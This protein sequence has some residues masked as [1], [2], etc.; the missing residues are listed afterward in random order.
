M[1]SRI[2][3]Q[4][5]LLLTELPTMVTVED[6]DYSFEFSESYTANLHFSTGSESIPF[7]MPLDSALEQLRQET[8]NS[9]LLTIEHNTV[10]IFTD[11][12]GILKIFD[13]HARDSFGMPHSHGTC[14]LLEFDSIRN[15]T[16]YLKFIYRFG[17]IFELRG[18]KIVNIGCSKQLE[19]SN[20]TVTDSSTT[21]NDTNFNYISSSAADDTPRE[22]YFLY[23]REC[24]LYIYSICFSTIMNC[25]YWTYQTQSDIIEH[26]IEMYNNETINDK[27]QGSKH[28]PGSIEICGSQ[29]DIVNTS[30]HEGTLCLA[31]LSSRV[32]LET[33]I[34]CNAKQNTGF[35]IW[36]SNH[37]LGCV[38]VNQR[39]QTKYFI[40][41]SSETRELNLLKPFSDPHPLVSRFCDILELTDPN[42]EE[43]EYLIQFLSCKTTL[44]KSEKQKVQRK[45]KYTKQ[46]EVLCENK[47]K[48]YKCMDP[49]KRE[50]LCNKNALKYKSL[51]PSEKEA[52]LEKQ[53]MSYKEMGT[54]EKEAC[55]ERNKS[56]MK[57]KYHVINSPQKEKKQEAYK[58]SKSTEHNLDYFICNFQNKIREG[59]CYICCVCNRL[60]Y[61]KSVKLLNRNSCNSSVPKSVF[62]NITSFDNKEYICSTCH[63]KVA[64]GKI[65]CQ[66]VCNNMSVDEIPV[67][68][69]LLEKLEQILIA[70]RIV[71]EKII[72]MP[73][74]QQ[75]KVSGAICNVPVDC[76]Q[77]CKVLPR[78]P[79]RS[80][81]IMLKLK[82]KL[83]FRGHVYFQAVR[84][85]F[86]ENALNWLKLNNPLYFNV[87]TEMNNIN[88][89]L[90]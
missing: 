59:P 47:T 49:I 45:H 1:L 2:S 10:S 55:L 76:D 23:T 61:K 73:K 63:S 79:E 57:R 32:P 66:A 14:V 24:S 51:N 84:P 65:P 35:F 46:K 86:I 11:S 50:A 48:I 88:V 67:E 17:A 39:Q 41:S 81:I 8:F 25:S 33:V 13:S 77:T 3:R 72:I 44:T 71:F 85:Q 74:G 28:F 34:L 20:E 64:K 27:N 31:S 52:L 30:I 69:A 70:Q 37:C 18:V 54:S 78:P 42:I 9:F 56:N 4:S 26:A 29:I 90:K 36:L 15:F 16:E 80:G 75:K 68:L 6:T 7:V 38:I 62:T 53:A 87:T 40:L 21:N 43:V 83:E 82:R 58:K 5:Y 12:S 19:N 22:N 60:L 89:N